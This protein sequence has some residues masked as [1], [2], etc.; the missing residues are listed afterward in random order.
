MLGDG[1]ARLVK[2]DLGLLFEAGQRQVPSSWCFF[3]DRSLSLVLMLGKRTPRTCLRTGPHS[4]PPRPCRTG[5]A[6]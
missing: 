3:S 6:Y 5:D 1:I 2:V 4:E